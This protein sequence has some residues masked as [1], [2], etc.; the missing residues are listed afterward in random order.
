MVHFTLDTSE[1]DKLSSDLEKVEK[2]GLGA[3][4]AGRRALQKRNVK[5]VAP[6]EYT[7]ANHNSDKDLTAQQERD[8][9]RRI[10]AAYKEAFRG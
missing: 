3:I 4:P 8:L 2:H 9:Q 5:Q 1:L 6:N 10:S 7:F